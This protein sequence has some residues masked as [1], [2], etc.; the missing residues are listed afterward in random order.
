M[1]TI[2]RAKN[3]SKYYTRGSERIAALQDVSFSLPQGKY[4]AVVGPSGSGKT[5]LLNLLG[6][7]DRPS[8]RSIFIND[9]EASSLNE[10]QLVAVRRQNIGFVFQQFFLLPTLTRT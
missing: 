9:L 1:K 8:S 4:I 5:T 3:L 7:L 2:I 6:C 10:R